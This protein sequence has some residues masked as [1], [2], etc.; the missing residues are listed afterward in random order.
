MVD[1]QVTVTGRGILVVIGLTLVLTVALYLMMEFVTIFV[2]LVA[3][4]A[5]ALYLTVESAIIPTVA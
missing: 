2:S 3:A 5:V 1:V 4:P